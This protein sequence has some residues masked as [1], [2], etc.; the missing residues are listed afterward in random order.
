M[1][2]RSFPGWMKD[3]ARG[4]QKKIP[5]AWLNAWTILR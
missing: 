5:G 1:R 3:S 2:E 4:V